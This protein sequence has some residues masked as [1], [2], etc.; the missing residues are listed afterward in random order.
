LSEILD[1]ITVGLHQVT[2]DDI[3]VIHTV[4]NNMKFTTPQLCGHSEGSL[5]EQQ[6]SIII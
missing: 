5:A 1:I 6:K 4:T 2:K 3:L